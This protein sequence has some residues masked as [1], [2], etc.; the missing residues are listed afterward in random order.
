MA[1]SK[2]TKEP[3]IEAGEPHPDGGTGE[4]KSPKSDAEG[5]VAFLTKEPEIEA[6]ESKSPKSDAEGEVA[7]LTQLSGYLFG[8][9]KAQC[10]S[11]KSGFELIKALVEDIDA[12]YVNGRPSVFDNDRWGVDTRFFFPAKDVGVVY[13][14]FDCGATNLAKSNGSGT[15]LIRWSREDVGIRCAA[16]CDTHVFTLSD[17][18]G[19][20]KFK[21]T[22]EVL[23]VSDLSQYL[24]LDNKEQP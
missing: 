10:D 5:E 12:D 16:S 23:Y 13:L 2:L 7:F 17:E 8:E 24:N 3:E 20:C 9:P 11:A 1:R 18:S 22:G 15:H 21:P 4:S 19:Q 6:G 14:P